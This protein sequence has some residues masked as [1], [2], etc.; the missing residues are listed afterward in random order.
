MSKLKLGMKIYSYDWY[1]KYGLD[2]DGAAK[3]LRRQGVDFVIAQNQLIP[4]MNTAAKAEVPRQYLARFQAYDDR[5]F[6]EALRNEGI[7]YWASALMFFHPRETAA[8]GAVPVDIHGRLSEK[9][10]WYIGACPSNDA[11]VEYRLG[12]IC[13]AV[14]ELEPDGIFLGFMRFPGFWETWLPDTN[15]ALWTEYC[16]C[17]NCLR[18]YTKWS[19][20]VPDNAAGQFL[21]KDYST[22]KAIRLREIISELRTRTE[23]KTRIML[24]TLAFDEKNYGDIR[25]AVFGQNIE[26]LSDVVDVFEIMAYHQI[27]ARPVSWVADAAKDIAGRVTQRNKIYVTIQGKPDYLSG[28]HAGLGRSE[29]V[30]PEDVTSIISDVKRCG[31]ADGVIVYSWADFLEQKF[32][33]GSEEHIEAINKCL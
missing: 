23:H 33:L 1:W 2:Y 24:N 5:L 8:Y 27:L 30:T 4:S 28:M 12:Q 22:W 13:S 9:E 17:D 14:Q 29:N 3:L 6:R 16:F 21:A 19:G 10:D 15:R 32:E 25:S 18:K 7:E 11:Y 31:K 26:L 20:R